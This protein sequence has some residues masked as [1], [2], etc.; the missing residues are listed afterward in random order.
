M[1]V[2]NAANIEKDWAWCLQQNTMG[3]E[4]ENASD[5]TAQLA[6][7]G[8]KA[9]DTL[10]KLNDVDLSSIPYY[11]FVT[12][13]IA[14]VDKV[15]ISNTGYT[16]A[17]GFELYFYPEFGKQ[18]WD[19]IFDA[20]KEF[21]IKPA[22]LGARDTLRLEMGFCLYGNDLDET[23]TPLQAGL[24]WITKFV[25]GNDFIGRKALEAEKAAGVPRKL[26]GFMLVE[27]GIPRQ[28][29]EI[30]NEN[31]ETIGKVTSGTISPILKVGIGLGYVKPEYAKPGTPIYINIRNKPVKAEVVKPPFRK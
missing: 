1:M 12:G 25:D 23:T 17:G 6:V 10:Q 11:S 19:A 16:G 21:G 2:V 20:G 4:I 9:K 8:P 22:G 13:E 31:R 28:G 7:Q 26:C 3:A 15:I 14:G 5:H 18:I 29:Y 30:E 24:G 27:K